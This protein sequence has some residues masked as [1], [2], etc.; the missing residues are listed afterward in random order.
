MIASANRDEARFE[1]PGPR[2]T[3]IAI[4]SAL[5]RSASAATSAAAT[6][7]R[8]RRSGSL[9]ASC[10]AASRELDACRRA[11]VLRLGVPRAPRAARCASPEYAWT[12]MEEAGP[13]RTARLLGARRSRGGARGALAADRRRLGLLRAS[14]G[15]RSRRSTPTCSSASTLGAA[16]GAA[17]TR[18]RSSPTPLGSSTSRTRRRARSTSPTSAR[19]GSRSGVLA[20]AL[21]ATYDVN[22]AVTARAAD[23]VEA[24]AVEWVAEFVGYP[25]RRGRVHERRHDLEPDR[26]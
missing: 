14:R 24:Q 18:P 13:S 3:S 2:S 26:R 11:R 10:C 19:P 17:A 20:E 7:S 8:A 22:L 23:L 21:A 4:D 6:L 5:R 12:V 9:C 16:R 15:P 1:R 25:V